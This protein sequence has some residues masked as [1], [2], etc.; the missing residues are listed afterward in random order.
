VGQDRTQGE[1]AGSF[2]IV[3]GG[4]ARRNPTK[5]VDC[6]EVAMKSESSKSEENSTCDVA[7]GIQKRNEK[8]ERSQPGRRLGNEI[9][10]LLAPELLRL[11]RPHPKIAKIQVKVTED[12]C[13][14]VGGF[15]VLRGLESRMF[16]CF[17]AFLCLQLLHS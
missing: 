6:D 13:S 17:N 7:M 4:I 14:L 5:P 12:H 8:S 9:K 10:T 1:I 15:R 16:F 3:F 11:G 2:A